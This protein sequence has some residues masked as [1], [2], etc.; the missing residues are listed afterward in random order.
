MREGL[1]SHDRIGPTMSTLADLLVLKLAG[2]FTKIL[3]EAY[4]GKG[5]VSATAGDLVDTLLGRIP[6]EAEKRK[7]R[8]EFEE[9]GDRMARELLPLFQSAERQGHLNPEAVV[10]ALE[11]T[12]D[13]R[14]TARFLVERDLE[15]GRI[16][17]ELYKS[18]PLPSGHFSEAETELYKR[19]LERSVRQLV[20]MASRLPQFQETAAARS[21]QQLS[22]VAADV[23]EI[24]GAVRRIEAVVGTEVSDRKA[25]QYE[26]EYR[27]AVQRNL[28]YVEIFGIDIPG[29]WRNQKL[30]V[31]YVSLN[32]QS[33]SGAEVDLLSAEALFDRLVSQGESAHRRLLIRGDAGS[34]KSTLFRWLATQAAG[35]GRGTV[36]WP[37]LAK[38][39]WQEYQRFKQT[40]SAKEF[41]G[42][43]GQNFTTAP[44][45]LQVPFLVRLRHCR[46][47]SLPSPDEFP[48]LIANEIGTPPADW[49]KSILET[50][51]GLVLL[52]GL[53]EIPNAQRE[54]TRRQIHAL[55]E[56]YPESSYVVSTRPKAVAMGWLADLGFQETQI[57]L[58]SDLDRNL[59]IDRWHQAFGGR[60]KVLGM[61]TDD[62]PVLAESLK[63]ELEDNRDV[64]RLATNPLLCAMICALHRDRSRK[65]PERQRQLCEELCAALLHRRE[66]ESDLNLEDFPEPYRRLNYEQKRAAVQE[67][68]HYMVLNGY[69][70]VQLE[71]A[72]EQIRK[73]LK[74]FPGQSAEDAGIVTDALVERSG[75]LREESLKEIGFIHNAFKELLAG[76]YFADEGDAGLL[77]TYAL[78]P[79]LQPVV[80]YAVASG[81]RRFADKVVK[82]ILEPRSKASKAEQRARQ[83]MA[84][85]CRAAAVYLDEELD[86]QLDQLA[87]EMF[88]PRNM[89]DAEALASGGNTAVPF[90]R[91]RPKLKA[92]EAAACV[93]ALRLIG[94][95]QA[96]AGLREFLVD[97]R[98]TVVFE[99]A[100][101]VDPLEIA[102]VREQLLMGKFLPEGIA[103]QI[104]DLSLLAGLNSLQILYLMGTLVTDL[105]PLAGLNNLH[106]LDLMG[107]QVTDLSPLAGLNNLQN[108]DLSYT[109]VMDL[110]PLASLNNLKHLYLMGTQ[111]KDLSPLAGL[112]NLQIL[113]LDGTQVTD[114]SPLAGLNGLQ[115][116]YLTGTLVTDFSPL[117]ELKN[118]EIYSLESQQENS[119]DE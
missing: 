68:A 55:V 13:D 9:L 99:L 119:L 28:D 74:Q 105:S 116:L 3:A 71:Q 27:L 107:T 98:K 14:T 89:E 97:R 44:D 83:L 1:R 76:D 115:D 8:R 26:I 36:S 118:L 5:T 92:I 84:L 25:Q 88:P 42:F 51:R 77:A 39:T 49:V 56:H 81:R 72:Q 11:L 6:G 93:R 4:F 113:D 29:E 46:A 66:R 61:G 45:Q 78:N 103:D 111:V 67:L 86:H 96:R 19:A 69:S 37:L 40:N 91:Y 33:H 22:A 58:M 75:I 62:L 7:A 104:A 63:R 117:A 15:P 32:L 54:A 60:L 53:D 100:Q 80:L 10:Y 34:G 17:E 94:T 109:G 64:A 38:N 48:A 108:L 43:D 106:H 2:R 24:L 35:T 23:D 102:W 41:M 65:L 112:N 79:D 57:N 18:R 73:A 70:S 59:F 101:A 12:L 21:L 110:S 20:S 114:L 47:G 82:E 95:P 50:G 87:R 52:D 31:A 16:L 30:S 85:R 90:L